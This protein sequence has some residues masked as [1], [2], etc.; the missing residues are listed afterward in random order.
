M[1]EHVGMYVWG[2]SREKEL[3]CYDRADLGRMAARLGTRIVRSHLGMYPEPWR[4][5]YDPAARTFVDCLREPEWRALIAAHDT[6]VLTLADGSGRQFEPEWTKTHYRRLAEYLL[7]QYAAERKTFI[8]GLWECDHWL[9]E[10]SMAEDPAN[11]GKYARYFAARHEGIA[12]GRAALSG[13]RSRVY[14]MIEMVSLDDAGGKYLVNRAIPGTHADLY[15]L[16]SWGYQFELRK[17]FDLIK[18]RAPDSPDFGRRNCMVGEAGGAADWAPPSERV[19]KTRQILAQARAWGLPYVVW[20][21]LV[22]AIGEPQFSLRT[23]LYEGGARLAPYYWFYRAY[24]SSDDP[25]VIEDFE[26][27]PYGAAAGDCSEEGRSLNCIGG[28][29]DVSGDAFACLCPVQGSAR[30]ALYLRTGRS[31]GEW[32]TGL[33]RLDAR[34]FTRLQMDV[35]G[36]GRLRLALT[37]GRGRKA[38]ARLPQAGPGKANAWRRAAVPL[39]GLAGADLGDLARLSV[40]ADGPAAMWLHDLAF[41]RGSAARSGEE[42]PRAFAPQACQIALRSREQALAVP[43]SASGRLRWLRIAPSAGTRVPNPSVGSGGASVTLAKEMLPGEV[44]EVVAGGTTHLRFGPLGPLL[45]V[46]R[47]EAAGLQ[48]HDLAGHPQYHTLQPAGDG[49][50]CWLQWRWESPFAVRHFRIAL[51]GSCRA[52][53]RASAAVL[54]SPDGQHW[55][56]APLDERRWDETFWIARTPPDFRPSE[57]FWVRFRILPDKAAVDWQWTV[58]ICDVK[59]ELW[60]DSEGCELPRLA[61]LRYRDAGPA[62]GLRGLLDLDW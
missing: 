29:R 17:A 28:A 8:L 4:P 20:W 16:S 27:D 56:E 38:A 25:L 5:E 50:D 48:A 52:G 12:A 55:I 37:D 7:R 41:A 31:G 6:I 14:E 34:R 18:G 58:G 30:R 35:R 40:Q 22:G 32:S 39:K 1:R 54:V 53:S 13:S 47:P 51:Y 23:P 44:L 11:V 62:E 61:G 19:E 59:V 36:D 46:A 42:V 33:M 15:S 24:H 45:D 2:P 49:S 57:R 21:E 43:G 60:L 10:K 26:A 9:T 3:V